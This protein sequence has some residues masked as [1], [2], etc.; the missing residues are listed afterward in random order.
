MD[1]LEL[2]VLAIVSYPALVLGSELWFSAGEERSLNHW[3]I[4]LVPVMFFIKFIFYRPM[5]NIGFKTV[6]NQPQF[7]FLAAYF[8]WEKQFP[9]A[10]TGMEKVF[11]EW[12]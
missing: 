2:Q 6:Q 12:R 10:D 7:L 9:E 8:Q 3:V 4:S 5:S 1:P 11:G